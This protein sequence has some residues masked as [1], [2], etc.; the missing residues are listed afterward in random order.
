MS[1]KLREKETLLQDANIKIEQLKDMSADQ[2]ERFKGMLT[3][4][5]KYLGESMQINPETAGME[6]E[7]NTALLY[8][9]QMKSEAKNL[10][11]RCQNLETTQTQSEEDMKSKDEEFVK[12]KA[13]HGMYLLVFSWYYIF[14]VRCNPYIKISKNKLHNICR[15]STFR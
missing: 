8:I 15:C 12:L 1:K 7:F 2:H 11:Q 9:S 6:K 13:E 4:I 10:E 14:S 3:N 5:L